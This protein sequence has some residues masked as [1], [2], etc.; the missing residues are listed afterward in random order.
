MAI[1]Y[2]LDYGLFLEILKKIG[3]KLRV[4]ENS[5]NGKATLKTKDEDRQ[6]KE[7]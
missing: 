7:A 2:T 1:A 3:G 5:R 4:K 6:Q